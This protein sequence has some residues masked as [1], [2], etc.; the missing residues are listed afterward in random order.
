MDQREC[1][2]VRRCDFFEAITEHVTLEMRRTITRGDLHQ[3]FRESAS[4]MTLPELLG[5]IWPNANAGDRKTMNHWTKL[6]NACRVLSDPAFRGTRQDLKQIFDLLDADGSQ[7]LSMSELI[8]ARILTKTEAGELH[9]N[10]C[11][12]INGKEEADSDSGSGS[13]KKESPS[14]DFNE[15]CRMMQKHLTDKYVHKEIVDKS[16]Q[17]NCR[18]VFQASKAASQMLDAKRETLA[19]PPSRAESPHPVSLKA[20]ATGVKAANV[21]FGIGRHERRN[22]VDGVKAANAA[23]GI[24]RHERREAQSIVMAC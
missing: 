20:A 22:A 24:G 14:F 17:K 18:S 3:R 15:F 21:A 12:G 10:W 2:S 5:R 13:V 8:R 23:F 4:E 19:T 1:G 11:Q 6:R 7:T 9:K 16:W